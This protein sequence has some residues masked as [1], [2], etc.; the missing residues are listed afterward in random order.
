MEKEIKVE[1]IKDV[2]KV[3]ATEARTVAKKSIVAKKEEKEVELDAKVINVRVLDF[4]NEMKVLVKRT[5]ITLE[6]TD[7]T[8]KKH[9]IVNI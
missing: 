7:G 1:E 9:V 4:Y 5:E 3:E 8:N 6:I 2:A